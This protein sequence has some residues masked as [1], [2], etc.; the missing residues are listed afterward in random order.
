Q[1]LRDLTAEGVPEGD[2]DFRRFADMRYAGQ[3][4]TVKVR[5][6]AG[7]ID[8]R[9]MPDINERFHALHQQTYTF[10]LETPVELVNYHLTAVGRVKKPEFRKLDGGQGKLADASKGAR[11]VNFDELGFAEAAIYERERLPVGVAVKGPAVVEEPASTT[12]VFPDQKLTRD[13]FG[14]LHI[15]MLG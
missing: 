5:L 6:P 4:H 1:A 3:E 9:A 14:F 13:E 7:A 8:E 10:R 12:V 2:M 11:R 15:E